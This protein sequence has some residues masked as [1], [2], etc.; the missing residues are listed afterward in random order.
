MIRSIWDNEIIF[1]ELISALLFRKRFPIKE[2]SLI[3]LIIFE[4]KYN[5]TK[6]LS[7]STFITQAAI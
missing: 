3:F 5:K 4:V 7:N 1:Q 6:I 2:Q